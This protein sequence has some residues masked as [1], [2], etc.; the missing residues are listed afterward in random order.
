MEK[1][2]LSKTYVSILEET[3]KKSKVDSGGEG[4]GFQITY[5]RHYKGCYYNLAIT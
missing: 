1:C 5:I 4:G 2:E 3:D